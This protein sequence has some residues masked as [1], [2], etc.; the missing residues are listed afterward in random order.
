M[1]NPDVTSTP[2]TLADFLV[3]DTKLRRRVLAL[4]ADLGT[5]QVGAPGTRY[6]TAALPREEV[7]ALVDAGLV[8]FTGSPFHWTAIVTPAG[9]EAFKAAR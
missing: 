4:A 8:T 6:G 1:N 3:V 5:L 7:D 9:S 2:S